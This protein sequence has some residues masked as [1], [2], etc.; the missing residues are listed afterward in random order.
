[1]ASTLF[2]SAI[3]K[4]IGSDKLNKRSAFRVVV[5]R[6]YIR[7][8]VHGNRSYVYKYIHTVV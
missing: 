1:M 6:D 3:V 2:Q 5:V 8:G 4:E 7:D